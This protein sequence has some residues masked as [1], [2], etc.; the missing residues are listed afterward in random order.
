[1]N[2]QK[3]I[4]AGLFAGLIASCS[5]L[6]KDQQTATVDV[7]A[8]NVTLD[9]L[10][11]VEVT[12][13]SSMQAPA[14]RMLRTEKIVSTPGNV[15]RKRVELV[16]DYPDATKS[17]TAVSLD[18]GPTNLAP[19]YSERPIP[20]HGASKADVLADLGQPPLRIP[21]SAGAEV[22]DYGTFRVFFQN[23]AVAFTRVW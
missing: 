4:L 10:D 6:P 8:Q 11:L 22:W 16:F 15:P 7:A 19:S 9:R 5:L 2:Y 1:M 12:A 18:S 23:E 21:G 14:A 13:S 17:S 3:P 20:E